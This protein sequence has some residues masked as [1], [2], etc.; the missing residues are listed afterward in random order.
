MKAAAVLP[1]RQFLG[2]V[3]AT[4]TAPLVVPG[5][6]L[7]LNGATAPSE[8]IVFGAIGVGNRALYILP[9]F[10]SQAD[11]HFRGHQRRA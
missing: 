5:A 8:K 2:R 9:N 3:L 6:V 1:R 11:L 10:L 4:A 7:G